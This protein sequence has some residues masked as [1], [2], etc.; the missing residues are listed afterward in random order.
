MADTVQIRVFVN[1]L[2]TAKNK[3][4]EHRYAKYT[5][6][7]IIASCKRFL[8]IAFQ[9]HGI[10]GHN[11][12]DA[13]DLLPPK[14]RKNPVIAPSKADQKILLEY[15][16]AIGDLVSYTAIK[17]AIKHAFRRDAYHNI[18]IAGNKAVIWTKSKNLSVFFDSEDLK[19]W[20]AFPLNVYTPTQLGDRV[21]RFLKEAY[22][23]GVVERRYTFHKFRHA[24]AHELYMETRDVY[25]VQQ[26][27]GHS[28]LSATDAYLNTLDKELLLWDSKK[29]K[30]VKKLYWNLKEALK[31]FLR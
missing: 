11:P 2:K 10:E 3:K 8:D 25:A 24:A 17:L 14:K 4:G 7:G 18:E 13:D 6:R 1:L 20:E 15:A 23:K 31:R 26:L 27:L 28:T 19:L 22:L 9:N 29:S 12:F 5:I 21:N 30:G 16:L